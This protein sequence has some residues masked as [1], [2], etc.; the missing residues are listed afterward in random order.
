MTTTAQPT[1]GRLR[2][3]DFTIYRDDDDLTA[4]ESTGDL[5]VV[6]G[7]TD[8]DRL[9]PHQG[10]VAVVLGA[11]GGP[12]ITEVLVDDH[13]DALTQLD[14]AIFHLTAARDRLAL[15]LEVDSEALA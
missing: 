10:K 14:R 15:M 2:I 12:G 8:Y 9:S 11:G 7:H 1:K 5:T 6:N 3:R 13:L 4:F